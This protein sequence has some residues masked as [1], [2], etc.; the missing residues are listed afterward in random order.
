MH[1]QHDIS[2]CRGGNCPL[3]E[4]CYRYK[5]HQNLLEN[6]GKWGNYHSYLISPPY[7]YGKCK[8]FWDCKEF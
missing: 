3:K 6:P 5:M 8:H 2:H 7:N 4:S 1:I